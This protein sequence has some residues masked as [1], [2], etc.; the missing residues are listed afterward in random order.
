MEKYKNAKE[1]I[2]KWNISLK[3]DIFCLDITEMNFPFFLTF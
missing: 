1:N 2:M 3:K